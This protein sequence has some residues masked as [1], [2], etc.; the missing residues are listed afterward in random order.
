ML[1]IVFSRKSGESSSPVNKHA[2]S[3]PLSMRESHWL[4]S[5][6]NYENIN[7]CVSAGE[8]FTSHIAPSC[9]ELIIEPKKLR[10]YSLQPTDLVYTV[11]IT[12]HRVPLGIFIANAH[13]NMTILV[14]Y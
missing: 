3:R 4:L 2:L 14:I 13:V 8:C 11:V 6:P 12:K 10:L 7:Q 5:I 1:K 9:A